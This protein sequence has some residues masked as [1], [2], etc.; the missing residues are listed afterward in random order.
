[1]ESIKEI[2]KRGGFWFFKSEKSIYSLRKET[3]FDDFKRAYFLFGYLPFIVLMK[4]LEERE[5]FYTCQLLLDT[6]SFMA[7][8]HE[9][10]SETKLNSNAV[11][12]MRIYYNENGSKKQTFD[13]FLDKI[14]ALTDSLR[15]YLIEVYPFFAD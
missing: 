9:A 6:V 1:M 14:P 2:I 3:Y 8:N 15:A 4:E 11:K 12:Q 5:Y 7:E 13:K 10:P